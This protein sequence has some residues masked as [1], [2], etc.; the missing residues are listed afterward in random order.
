MMHMHV[1]RHVLFEGLG[2][3][4]P[5]AVRKGFAVTETRF[6]LNESLPNPREIDW[7]VIMGGPMSVHDERDYPW[8][9]PEK[10]FIQEVIRL[11]RTVLG[12]CLGA[13]LIAETLGGEVR[14]NAHKEIGWFPVTLTD[15][16]RT[17]MPF[18]ALPASFMAFHWHGETFDIPPGALHA[19]ESEACTA[20]AFT[21]NHR[22]VGLQ[23][24]LECTRD[25]VGDMLIHCGHELAP[26]PGVQS[27]QAIQDGCGYTTGM[28]RDLEMLLEAMFRAAAAGDR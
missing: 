19:A 8:L 20:Q 27:C 3:I 4:E 9:A 12:I 22:V 28:H 2:A 11:D 24:H 10:T 25:S 26:A 23:F 17:S 5:W 1:L 15:S 16:G 7:L 6:W 14:K 18:N 21:Y 13:Q